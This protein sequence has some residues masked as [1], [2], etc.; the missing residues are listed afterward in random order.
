MSLFTGAKRTFA[1]YIDQGTVLNSKRC[2]A[3]VVD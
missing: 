2:I 3:D 1:T